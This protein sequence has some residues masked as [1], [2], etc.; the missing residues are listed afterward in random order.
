MKL[1]DFLII[2]LACGAPLGVYYFF[3]HRK[4]LHRNRLVL[5]SFL[6]IA[7]WIPY[8]IK[9]LHNY[10]TRKLITYKFAHTKEAEFI[11]KAEIDSLE[12]EIGNILL[13]ENSDISLFNFRE[14][15]QRYAGL[16][17]AL[18]ET[19]AFDNPADS[20]KELFRVAG[21]QNVEIGGIC[22]RR[23]NHNRLRFHQNLARRDI[24]EMF[25]SINA[26]ISAPDVF[27]KAALKFFRLLDDEAAF[28]EIRNFPALYSQTV[29]T[30][31]VRTLERDLWKTETQQPLHSQ[32]TPLRAISAVATTHKK[33]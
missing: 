31:N 12:K 8:A 25:G 21:N 16:S 6:T 9:L 13:K 14:T 32:P 11:L 18:R 28:E 24:I 29:D 27:N 33:D 19:S 10:V 15:F 1:S 4:D 17:I 26:E 3:Q 20:E 23:R 22:V 7:V 2:Y 5:N 30:L